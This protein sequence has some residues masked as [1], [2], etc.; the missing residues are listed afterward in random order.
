[1][2]ETAIASAPPAEL[3]RKI[4]E[5]LAP[6]APRISSEALGQAVERALHD[7]R[8]SVAAEALPEMAIRLA[9]HRLLGSD[10]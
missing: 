8:G 1:M 7:L 2:T 3:R 6:M 9:R 4:T 5:E 10:N